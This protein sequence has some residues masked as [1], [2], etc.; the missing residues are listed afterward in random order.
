MLMKEIKDD[1]HRWKDIPCSCIERVSIVKM[2]ILSKAIYRFNAILI[3]LPMAFF[4]ELEQKYFQVSLEAQKTQNSQSYPEKEKW[5]WKNQAPWLHTILQSYSHKNH[6]VLTHIN[7]F[8]K[9]KSNLSYNTPCH[10]VDEET[11]G[12]RVCITCLGWDTNY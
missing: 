2:I 11:D 3:K 4:I 7:I 12:H 8:S 10:F 9:A 1:T 6:V 5:T